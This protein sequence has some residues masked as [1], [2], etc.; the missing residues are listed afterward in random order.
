[1]I[2]YD[3]MFHWEAL[4][5]SIST[6]KYF[7]IFFLKDFL[8]IFFS[9]EREKKS[10]KKFHDLKDSTQIINITETS[11]LK[12]SF[13]LLRLWFVINSLLLYLSWNLKYFWYWRILFRF[14]LDFLKMCWIYSFSI[15]ITLF[16]PF[17]K[18]LILTFNEFDIIISR[19]I[20]QVQNIL[21][22]RLNNKIMKKSL[23]IL[24]FITSVSKASIDR[25][26]MD[27]RVFINQKRREL[28]RIWFS[29]ACYWDYFGL[30]LL[31]DS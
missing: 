9:F 21:V 29:W 1:M 10:E 17:V 27:K 28:L 22:Q 13:R 26:I 31:L 25:N 23:K 6:R 11:V 19:I 14:F 20:V 16:E 18:Y 2:S 30:S 15:W 5:W 24:V 3:S 4:L 7:W 8:G 12:L